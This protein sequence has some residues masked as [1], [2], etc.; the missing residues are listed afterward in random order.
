[1]ADGHLNICKECK[2][3]YAKK[4]ETELRKIPEWAE[5]QRERGRKKYARLYRTSLKE[6]QGRKNIGLDYY[7]IYPEKY[8]ARIATAHSKK[9]KGFHNHHWSYNDEHLKDIIKLSVS[10]H[11]KIHCYMTYDQER[12]MYRTYINFST[13]NL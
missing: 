9:E 10:D 3:N 13:T 5:N 1:M 8:K 7:K 6:Y 11:Y 2:R 4:K 12:K